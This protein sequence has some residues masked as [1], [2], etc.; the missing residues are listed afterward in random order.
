MTLD[1]KLLEA[2]VKIDN[3][4]QQKYDALLV[5]LYRPDGRIAKRCIENAVSDG[6]HELETN[7]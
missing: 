2:L 6:F 3:F 5:W 7:Q 1:L 4:L